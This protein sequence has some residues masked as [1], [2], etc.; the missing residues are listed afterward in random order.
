MVCKDKPQH[1]PGTCTGG[2]IKT[3]SATVGSASA[4]ADRNLPL[5]RTTDWLP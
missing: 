2:V 5:R 3:T 4:P 1:Y